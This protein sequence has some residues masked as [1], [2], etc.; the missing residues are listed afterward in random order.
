LAGKSFTL[1]Q[2]T[3]QDSRLDRIR[4][5]GPLGRAKDATQFRRFYVIDF[6]ARKVCGIVWDASKKT[7]AGR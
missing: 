7:L 3:V 5:D 1:D 2:L 4:T 6:H